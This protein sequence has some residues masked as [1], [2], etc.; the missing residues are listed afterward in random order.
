MS[1]E[2]VKKSSKG[3]K[4]RKKSKALASLALRPLGGQ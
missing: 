2:K 3:R 1:F 4:V